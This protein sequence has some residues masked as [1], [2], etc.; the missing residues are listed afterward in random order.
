[1]SAGHHRR[2]RLEAVPPVPRAQPVAE[3]GAHAPGPGHATRS[4]GRCGTCRSRCPR[5]RRSPSSARTAPARARCSSAWPASCGPRR[6]GSRPGA[7]SRRSSSSAPGFHPELTGRENIFLNGSILGLTQEAAR[8]ALRRDRRLRRP[9]ALHRH[10]GEEL[11]VGH[12]RAPRVLGGDQRRPRHPPDRRGARRRRRRVPAEVHREVRRLPCRAARPSSSCRTPSTPFATSA[13][14]WA[15]SSTAC[16]GVSGPSSEVIDEYL[17]ESHADRDADG[18][19][20]TRW[21]TGEARIEKF[22]VLDVSGEPV[23]RVRTGDTVVFRFHYKS[24]ALIPNPVWGMALYT[25]DGVWVTGP[26]T[27]EVGLIARAPRAR[28]AGLGRPACR[29]APLAARHV[30]RERLAVQHHAA[31]RY[32]TCATGRSGSTSSSAI[33]TRSTASCRWAGTW[34]GDILDRRPVNRTQGAARDARRRLRRDRELPRRRRHV[35]R[36]RLR[37]MI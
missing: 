9:R 31:R 6:G 30:R 26:N 15:G 20:G 19:H 21:G 7:R 28:S 11:L 16:S 1:M 17:T 5:A 14:R 33:R 27:Q 36:A 3:G 24:D 13:T 23:K 32:T 8:P 10:A 22:E 29:S 18:A 37:C 34:D 12:V 35:H 25:L 4:S 2:R